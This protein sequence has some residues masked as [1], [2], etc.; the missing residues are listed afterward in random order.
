MRGS[1]VICGVAATIAAIAVAVAVGAAVVVAVVGVAVAI[2]VA[3]AEAVA[4]AVAV[5]VAETVGAG[6]GTGVPEPG[7]MASK[8]ATS[9]IPLL[10][11]PEMVE[12]MFPVDPELGLVSYPAQAISELSG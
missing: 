6:V 2:G 3:V 5:G 11:G 7:E 1:A 4:V 10:A 8:N 12:V 9:C